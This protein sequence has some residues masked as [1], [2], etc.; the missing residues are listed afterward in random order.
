MNHWIIDNKILLIKI[1]EHHE[2]ISAIVKTSNKTYLYLLI[3]D[4]SSFYSYGASQ[5]FKG[6]GNIKPLGDNYYALNL[7]ENAK[8]IEIILFNENGKVLKHLT[9]KI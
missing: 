8:G 3:N 9:L 2:G 4:N 6:I 5:Q 1:K 7:P